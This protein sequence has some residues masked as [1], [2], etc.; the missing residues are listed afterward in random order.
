[1]CL[2]SMLPG[3]QPCRPG[4]YLSRV[5]GISKLD[6]RAEAATTDPPS[7]TVITRE[8]GRFMYWENIQ[9]QGYNQPGKSLLE[10]G[11][12]AKTKAVK[13]GLPIT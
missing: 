5:P 7:S 11:L 4:L 8:Y 3:A 2:P 10:T 13:P 12:G 1:M 6:I 9:R